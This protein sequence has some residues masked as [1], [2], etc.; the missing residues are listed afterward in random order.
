M[1]D[2]IKKGKVKVTFC[3]THDM[4]GDFFT[5]PLQRTQYVRMRSTTAS[6]AAHTSVLEESKV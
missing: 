5:K 2:K 6:T 3:P 1:T 4:L